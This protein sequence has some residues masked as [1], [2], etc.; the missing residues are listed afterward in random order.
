MP[1][2][3]LS[4]VLGFLIF[5]SWITKNNYDKRVGSLSPQTQQQ[6]ALGMI[7]LDKYKSLEEEVGALRKRSTALEKA[8]SEN[9]KGSSTLNDQLQ[10][11]KAFA[12]LTEL[13][14]PGVK[15]I[16]KDNSQAGLMPQDGDLIHDI[17]VLRVTNELFNAGAE[18]ISVNGQRLVSIT[19]IRCAG[20]IIN[21]NGVKVASP[22]VISAI[23]D[24]EMIYSGFTMSGGVMAEIASASPSMVQATKEKMLRVPPYLGSTVRKFGVVPK[25][26]KK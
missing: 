19:D 26:T 15:V 9:S 8:I 25:V 17:D 7:D 13:E 22:F 16:L 2:S 23:G 20:T 1:V 4:A 11:I 12:G 10:E 18:A 3:A 14:G 5:A 6:W 21:V 24:P